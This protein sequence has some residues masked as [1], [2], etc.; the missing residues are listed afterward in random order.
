MKKTVKWMVIVIIAIIAGCVIFS[1]G[2]A[3]DQSTPEKAA[4]AYFKAIEDVDVDAM[5][6][7]TN[8]SGEEIS[9][10]MRK[11]L[12]DQLARQKAKIFFSGCTIG[13]ISKECDLDDGRAQM[14]VPVI[15]DSGRQSF[16]RMTFK[17]VGDK[18][19][20]D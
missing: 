11:G 6:A 9:D 13:E 15:E 17:K 1:G 18:W 20:K 4:E 16:E 3:P 10:R 12:R 14:A 8:P 2:S 19:Y 7:L 5:I